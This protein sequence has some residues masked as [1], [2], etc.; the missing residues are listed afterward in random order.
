MTHVTNPP[1][2]DVTNLLGKKRPHV[3]DMRE[4]FAESVCEMLDDDTNP[5]EHYETALHIFDK[6]YRDLRKTLWINGAKYTLIHIIHQSKQ[7]EKIANAMYRNAYRNI[8]KKRR[9]EARNED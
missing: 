3:N 2:K 9:E 1:E 6:W 4:F 5:M 8:D 7:A